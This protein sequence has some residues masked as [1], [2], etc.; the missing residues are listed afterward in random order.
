MELE[1]M[2]QRALDVAQDALNGHQVLFVWVV[3]VKTHLLNG[4][5]NVRAREGEV[6]E[7]PG[8]T[9]VLS[10]VGHGS[11]MSTG[12]M[13]D[14]QAVM[15]ALSRISAAYLACERCMPEESRVTVMPR[16]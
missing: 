4:I 10:W 6:L 14:L 9:P 3:H 5:G 13:A 12:V 11:D 16:K 7:S 8:E 15:P 1:S 2:R